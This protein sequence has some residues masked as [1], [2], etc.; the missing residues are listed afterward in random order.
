M[1][2]GIRQW[3]GCRPRRVEGRLDQAELDSRLDTALAARTRQE[4]AR[5]LA[6]LPV[7]VEE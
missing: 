1:V 2:S 3:S 5:L 7:P 4:L 6:D